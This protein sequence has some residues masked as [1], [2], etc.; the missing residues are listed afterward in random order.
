MKKTASLLLTVI[1]GLLLAYGWYSSRNGSGSKTG[2]LSSIANLSAATT[3]KGKISLDVE[4]LFKDERFIE[5]ARKN[6]II[7]N[8]TRVGSREMITMVS[9]KNND[10][11]FASGL[12]AGNAVQEEA[13]K[14][15]LPAKVTSPLFSPVVIASWSKLGE[16]LENEGLAKKVATAQATLPVWLVDWKGLVSLMANRTKWKD[17]RHNKSYSSSKPILIS[18]TDPRKSNS[19]AL[20]LA[21]V[22][23]ELNNG[24]YPSNNELA[25]KS[26]FTIGTDF[27][28]RQGFQESYVNGAFDDWASIGI[29]KSPLVWVYEFQIIERGLNGGLPAGAAIFHTR[30]TMVNKEVLVS[31]SPNGDRVMEFFALPEVK[32]LAATKGLRGAPV[33]FMKKIAVKSG[34]DA[35][36]QLVDQVDPPNSDIMFTL[37]AG[38][39]E[40]LSN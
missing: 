10:F 11:F 22:S 2:G 7:F 18:T 23:K 15:G 32:E 39:A 12:V 1:F 5:L 26:G 27:F 8:V 36:M 35:D 28:K 21:M 14:I 34:V 33:E 29:G 19:A 17:L 40:A 13:K 3:I 30:P 24:E 4:P 20:Y 31:L 25:R 9:E 16:I 37:L 38:A 6:R